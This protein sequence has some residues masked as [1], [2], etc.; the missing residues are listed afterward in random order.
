MPEVKPP[1]PKPDIKPPDDNPPVPPPAPMPEVK[2]PPP[3][4]VDSPPERTPSSEK[5]DVGQFTSKDAVLLGRAGKDWVKIAPDSKVS[6]ADLLFA[7]PGSHA[8]LKLDTGARATL[9]GGLP[10]TTG[11]KLLSA[12]ATLHI[13][14]AG[15]DLD[16]TIDHGRVIVAGK[17][18]GPTKV[19]LRFADQ[20]WDL[21]LADEQTEVLLDVVRLFAG[22]PFR[23]DGTGE[24]PQTEAMLGVIAGK[25]DVKIGTQDFALQAPPG[26]AE[27]S[28]DGKQL[29]KP[30]ELDAAPAAWTKGPARLAPDRQLEIAAAQKKLVTRMGT[31]DKPIDL[32]VAEV[33]Q[34]TTRAAKVLG[35]LCE[36]ALGQLTP[37]FDQLEEPQWPEVRQAA[38]IAVAHFIAGQPS[39]DK[40]VF[41]Q[42]QAGKGYSER[43]AGQALR[44]LHGFMDAQLADP[45]TFEFLIDSLRSEQMGVR[46][47]AVWRL[48]QIDPEG[49]N[50]IRFN[51]ADAETGREKAVAEWQRRIP[52]GKLPP[53]PPPQSKAVEKKNVTG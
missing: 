34:D 51:A 40:Q 19:R 29:G 41:D 8:E 3:K 46:E 28:W 13:P 9:W 26:V 30:V 12:A 24:A 35:A 23:K 2:A 4:A 42:L 6:S 33:A 49:G 27:L 32:A 16:A 25:I 1:P 7:L 47:L 22:Q 48:R 10:D 31:K 15:F 39:N 17:K 36:G 14:P 45:T 44:L 18:A 37:L 21:T 11:W 52:P 20:V 38:A 43:Q 53:K 50:Q 5:K